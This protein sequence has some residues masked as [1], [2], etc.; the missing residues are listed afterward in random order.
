MA[1]DTPPDSKEEGVVIK[2]R[3]PCPKVTCS[4]LMVQDFVS[5]NGSSK[6]WLGQVLFGAVVGQVGS[7]PMKERSCH[8]APGPSQVMGSDA[9][10]CVKQTRQQ[11]R[12]T[13]A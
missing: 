1:Y 10:I 12:I 6:D 9:R 8:R 2:L 7:G 5:S 13:L 4:E 3:A 11:G